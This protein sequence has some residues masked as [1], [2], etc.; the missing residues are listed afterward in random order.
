M[1]KRKIS[2]EIKNL[3]KLKIMCLLRSENNMKKTLSRWVNL[4]LEF[5][6]NQLVHMLKNLNLKFLMKVY[7]K[8]ANQKF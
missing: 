4:G 6:Q 2:S 1:M 7:I 8:L 5:N 3:K